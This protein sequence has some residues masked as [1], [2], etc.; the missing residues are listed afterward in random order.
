MSKDLMLTA[1]FTVTVVDDKGHVVKTM[2]TALTVQG[3]GETYKKQQ[4]AAMLNELSGCYDAAVHAFMYNTDMPIY[5]P[6]EK[7]S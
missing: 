3:E 7:Y 6:S 2:N 1:V 5:D 4:K